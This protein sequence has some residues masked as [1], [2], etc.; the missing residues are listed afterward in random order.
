MAFAKNP[1]IEKILK[2]HFQGKDIEFLIKW[3]GLEDSHNC[4]IT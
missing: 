2:A 3:K 4:W 1:E